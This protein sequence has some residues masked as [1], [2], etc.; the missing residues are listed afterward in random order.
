MIKILVIDFKG[1]S[2]SRKKSVPFMQEANC[3]GLQLHRCNAAL[4][5]YR[6]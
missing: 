1:P 4:R 6:I 2:G 3:S 5:L